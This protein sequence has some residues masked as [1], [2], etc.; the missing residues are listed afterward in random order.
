MY[1]VQS[2]AYIHIFP[3]TMY[4]IKHFFGGL[5]LPGESMLIKRQ[6]GLVSTMAPDTAQDT[7]LVISLCRL[8]HSVMNEEVGWFGEYR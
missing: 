2:V 1:V 5:K 6:M 4:A 8:F 3:I 7:Q